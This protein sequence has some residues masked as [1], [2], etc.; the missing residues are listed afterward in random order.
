MWSRWSGAKIGAMSAG[1]KLRRRIH[2]AL[3]DAGRDTG[4]ELVFTEIERWA[5]DR[6]TEIED[7]REQL[8]TR[9]DAELAAGSGSATLVGLSG[10]IRRCVAHRAAAG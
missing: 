6:A 4:A 10:E 5:I 9:L 8:Q 3:R 7:R 2:A 1:D